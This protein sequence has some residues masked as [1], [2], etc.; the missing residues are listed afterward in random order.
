MPLIYVFHIAFY[1]L[2]LLRKLGGRSPAPAAAPDPRAPSAPHARALI[3]MHMVAFAV[4]YFGL[5]QAVLSRRGSPLLFP[6]QTVLGGAV[7]VAGGALLVSA[8]RVFQSWR[9]LAR[10]EE[11]HQLCTS[12]PFRFVR[13]PIYV[14]MDLLALGTFLWA[15]SLIVLVGAILVVLAGDL[16]GR[17]EERLLA[18]VF[19]DEYRAY[20]R[21]AARTIPGVY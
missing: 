17:G 1:A 8:L 2:F 12:G 7:I 14:S 18:D 10:I 21:R 20:C 6:P 19:G 16:R 4:L 9:L 5:G 3:A 11:G 15:P 13:H